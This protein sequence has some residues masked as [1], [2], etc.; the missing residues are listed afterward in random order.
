M[1][2]SDEWTVTAFH[3]S[4]VD[5]FMSYQQCNVSP[6]T[7]DRAARQLGEIRLPLDTMLGSLQEVRPGRLLYVETLYGD[8]GGHL[9]DT[10]QAAILVHGSMAHC[11]QVGQ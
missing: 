3:A 4:T 1:T 2:S 7:V 11:S 6:V 9:A 8:P 10:R 5:E